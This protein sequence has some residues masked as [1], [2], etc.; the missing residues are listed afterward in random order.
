MFKKITIIILGL[1]ILS[2]C[3]GF[4]GYF[5]KSA[6]NKMI[7]TKGFEGSKRKPLYNKKYIELAKRNVIE[8]NY[9]D[10]EDSDIDDYI[11]EVRNPP[12]ENRKIYREMIKNDAQRKKRNKLKK[13]SYRED[14]R[15]K[16]DKYPSL[17]EANEQ[18]KKGNFQDQELQKELSE[19][20]SMLNE[21][22]RDLVKYKCPIQQDIEDTK[23]QHSL[24]KDNI[25]PE[26]LPKEE[27]RVLKNP[28]P[29]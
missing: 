2:G 1:F 13:S 17:I 7:D 9:D 20:K 22:K 27:K 29:L 3:E 25:K 28:R 10:D 4:R 26:I 8:E 18:V 16:N 23:A 14:N 5:K 12:K 11:S 15:I 19:I 6:N 24:E 21:A